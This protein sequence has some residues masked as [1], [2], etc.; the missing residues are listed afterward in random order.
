[1][2]DAASG[3]ARCGV[4][5]RD[6]ERSGN[7]RARREVDASRRYQE[8]NSRECAGILERHELCSEAKSIRNAVR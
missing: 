1:M 4:F 5:R 2:F 8:H 3:L 6:G 7:D